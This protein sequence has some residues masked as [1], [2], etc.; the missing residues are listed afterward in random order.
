[1]G[2]PGSA[3]DLVEDLGGLAVALTGDTR[4]A[5]ALLGEVLARSGGAADGREPDLRA[6]LVARWLH[7]TRPRRRR[8]P[9]R[10]AGADRTASDP[11]PAP[12]GPPAPHA[13]SPRGTAT[14]AL[15]DVT[16]RLDA[17]APLERTLV[18]L[19]HRE[20]LTLPELATLVDRPVALVARTVERAEAD[21]GAEPLV[22]V[23]A[24]AAQPAPEVPAVLAAAARWRA[25]HRRA[26]TRTVLA[27]ALGLLLLGTAAVLPGVLERRS[28]YLRPYG[29]WVHG[30]ALETGG[31]WQAGARTLTADRDSLVVRRTG[32]GASSCLVDLLAARTGLT[33]P[34][35]ERRRLHGRP[36]TLV[37][38]SGAAAP[39][40]WWSLGPRTAAVVGCSSP[41]GT[42]TLL[43]L[44]GRIRLRA[45]PAIVPFDLRAVDRRARVRFLSAS[46]RSV[47]ALG[48][49]GGLVS[50][51]PTTV[52]VSLPGSAAIPEDRQLRTAVRVRGVAGTLDRAPNGGMALCWAVG[53]GSPG[54]AAGPTSSAP[55]PPPT[56][57][58]PDRAPA[59]A[60]DDGPTV[61]VSAYVFREAADPEQRR[62]RRVL[63][64]LAAALVPAPVVSDSGTWFDARTALPQ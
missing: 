55:P 20:Q 25:G 17:L 22:L 64:G 9:S 42:S 62:L 7:P 18:V 50:R 13:G 14:S 52:Y 61:C 10:P 53:D 28:T 30:F 8:H 38:G 24:L 43:D 3:R 44:A 1:V 32:A 51:S 27:A 34:S 47:V 37:P 23:E 41:V 5:T 6:L 4:A 2:G 35:G 45:V 36:A 60:A 46:E 58:A 63:D 39:Y 57:T 31:G 16:G 12:P 29:A 11:A 49:P 15:P 33:A 21:V 56:A 59:G 54:P 40:L 26:R 48:L 19:R